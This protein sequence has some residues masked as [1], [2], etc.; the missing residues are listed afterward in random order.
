MLGFYM[1]A[2]C[3]DEADAIGIQIDLMVC[4]D[5]QAEGDIVIEPKDPSVD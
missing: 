4:E 1:W 5:I 2:G 3:A